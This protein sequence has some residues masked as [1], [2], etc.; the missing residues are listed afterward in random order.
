VGVNT[1]VDAQLRDELE[2]ASVAYAALNERYT[3][4]VRLLNKAVF[5]EYREGGT[6]SD[7]TIRDIIVFMHQL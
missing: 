1:A 4:L 6:I 3:A 7:D 2:S 5:I